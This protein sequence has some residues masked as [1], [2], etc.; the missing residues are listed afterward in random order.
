M[1]KF[2]AMLLS[3]TLVFTLAACGDDPEDT[4]QEDDPL[5]LPDLEESE[6]V[7][8]GTTEF[9]GEFIFWGG[10]SS[11]DVQIR[12]SINGAGL[13]ATDQN[14][15]F[16]LNET[17]LTEDSVTNLEDNV[18]PAQYD[19]DEDYSD[20]D[21]FDE[22][23]NKTYEFTIKDD[24]QFSDGEPITAEDYAFA[25]K[26]GSAFTSARA[27]HTAPNAGDELV[28]YDDW[29]QG[30]YGEWGE[31]E[32]DDGEMEEVW[33]CDDEDSTEVDFDGVEVVDD[34]TLRLTIDAANLPYFYELSMVA[35]GPQPEHV[36]TDDGEYEFLT[37][38]EFE[39]LSDDETHIGEYIYSML[40][41]PPVSSGAYVLDHYEQ[42]QF[43]RLVKNDNYVGD[44]RGH[45]PSIE[46]VIVRV[47]PMATDIE[48]LLNEEIDV[49]TGV[50]EG[51]KIE[52]AM[53]ADHIYDTNYKRN[54]FG[55][56][57]IQTDFSPSQDY[58]VRQAIAHMI[59][60]DEF[61]EVFLEGYGEVINA[62][63]G[64][65]QWMLEDS[66]VV[67]DE[68]TNYEYDLDKASELLDDAGYT[69]TEDGGTWESADDGYRYHE[70]TGEELK[71]GWLG[72]ESDYSDILANY[73][74]PSMQEAGVN[75]NAQQAS[76]DRL[77]QNYYYAYQMD[78]SE[79]D[80][81]MF[82]LASSY[83]EVYDPYYSYHSD[84]LGTTY[85]TSQFEDSADNPQVDDFSEQAGQGFSWIDE[86]DVDGTGLT[87]DELTVKMRNLS[88]AETDKF[89]EYWEALSLRMN[90]LVPVIPLYSNQY[91]HFANE[92]VEGLDLTGFWD[93]QQNIVDWELVD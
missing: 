65:G 60:R 54:G 57:F 90:R 32:N 16:M 61:V 8:V 9:S 70:D 82:N 40:S 23:G 31:E 71:L 22:D 69:E 36:Y 52:R 58:R 17:V 39:D 7:T 37:Q 80:Y 26:M 24:M 81:Q 75:F 13:V 2:L 1:R 59:N 72:T 4:D 28:G 93:W 53:D 21:I 92:R 67:P 87:V 84:F 33:Q 3:L 89:Q 49:L 79:R 78:D 6:T 30:C 50:V 91:Y 14:G 35:F 51:S 62:P 66:D 19:P 48:H 11:Y 56:L 44:F 74:N 27:G 29:R 41:E 45:K 64:L 63:Y 12:E 46:N 5:D 47:V 18:L 88:P 76:F 68:L 55:A 34:Q 86:D 25:I 38:A 20:S 85:N 10:S 73:L 15:K 43:A 77:L 42:D 83:T